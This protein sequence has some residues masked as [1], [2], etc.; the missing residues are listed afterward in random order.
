MTRNQTNPDFPPFLQ[1]VMFGL[2]KG[3]ATMVETPEGFVVG[4]LAEVV[5]PD[6]AT[7]KAGYDQARRPSP[8]R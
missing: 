6:A 8:S 2:K 3:E 1:H 7:D 4:Q 5:K